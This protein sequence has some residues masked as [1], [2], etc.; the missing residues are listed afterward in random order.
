MKNP[1]RTRYGVCTLK[2]GLEFLGESPMWTV[3]YRKW[4]QRDWHYIIEMEGSM[5]YPIMFRT[6]EEAMNSFLIT[7]LN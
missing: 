6:K 1:F 4:Y 5:V 3:M 7:P 2:T